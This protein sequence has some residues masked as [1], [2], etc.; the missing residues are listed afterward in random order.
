MIQTI[1][2]RDPDSGAV[3]LGLLRGEDV[4]DV[5]AAV[6]EWTD[7][8]AAWTVVRALGLT[9][10]D[11]FARLRPPVAR[12]SPAR[13]ADAGAL[14]PPVAAE[15]V[16]AAGVTYDRSRQARNAETKLPDSVYDRVYD[17]ER[18]ELFL[19]ATGR[20]LLGSGQEV[21][22]RSD[23]S[24]MVPEPEL[25]VAIGAA[26][27]IVGW[28]LGNDLSSRDIEGENP[29]YLPQAKIFSRSCSLGP[30]LLWNTGRESPREWTLA[31]TIRRGG[32]TAFAGSVPL[33]Q[34]RR[35]VEALIAHLLRDNPVPAGTVLLT[36]TGI[37]PPDNF[38][39]AAGD[40][41]DI[42]IAQIG[43]LHNTVAPPL[44]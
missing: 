36:G 39:L 15:E 43:I 12:F 25:A 34:L 5:T 41:V 7:P 3:R 27:E 35:P 24:W 6:P 30:A 40:V 23:S 18:P 26:G 37:V 21:G 38:T 11:A 42:G 16:W 10:E 22:L 28:T 32:L 31:M 33:A 4:L 29:L 44:A 9:V 19:K 20:R 14:L 13:L 8:M 17:A 1:R 2:Y